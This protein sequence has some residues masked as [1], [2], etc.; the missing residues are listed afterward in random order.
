MKISDE[1]AK[2]L[3]DK[4]SLNAR[5]DL[6]FA[7]YLESAK[8]IPHKSR[9]A[10]VEADMESLRKSILSLFAGIESL[11]LSLV[12]EKAAIVELIAH[13]NR[14]LWEVLQENADTSESEPSD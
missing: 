7:K 12:S 13:N 14:I 5:L 1:D 2:L 6:F 3:F 8:G 10:N 9:I 11:Q 4:D